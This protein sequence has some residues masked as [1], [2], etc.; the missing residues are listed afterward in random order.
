MSNIEL[1]EKKK[2]YRVELQRLE[3]NFELYRGTDNEI[4]LYF[5]DEVDDGYDDWLK[6]FDPKEVKTA[7]QKLRSLLFGKVA[8][9]PLI[10]PRA[11]NCVY[12]HTCPFKPK[13]PVGK[14]CPVES[15][16]VIEKLNG[17]RDELVVDT[18]KETDYTLV[19]RLVELEIFDMRLSA[20]LAQG[21][22]QNPVYPQVFSVG[23]SGAVYEDQANPLYEMKE[24][25]SREK[26]KLLSVLVETP[27]AR[28]KKQA[29]LKEAEA[30]RYDTT[31]RDLE[32]LIASVENKLLI[33]GSK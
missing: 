7:A 29:A 26:I 2:G 33:E 1:V 17:Y 23:E 11:Q 28:Y 3:K 10:C 5:T 9:L 27:E 13:E 16:F 6:G 15:A 21:K 19:S 32:K 20:M 4:G 12:E 14:A 22:Y 18:F 31:L 24:K 25:L 8:H 30:G